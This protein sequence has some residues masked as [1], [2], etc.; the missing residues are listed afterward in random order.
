MDTFDEVED[1]MKV[2]FPFFCLL[3]GGSPFEG[4]E[5]LLVFV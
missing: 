3:G 1:M 2:D 5:C 4:D